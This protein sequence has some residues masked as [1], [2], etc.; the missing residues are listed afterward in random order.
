M[1]YK[2][3][4]LSAGLGSRMQMYPNLHKSLLPLGNRTVISRILDQFKESTIVVALGYKSSQVRSYLEFFHPDRHFEFVYVDNYDKRGSGPG[5]SLFCCRHNL[6]CP[7]VFTSSDTIVNP[8]EHDLTPSHDWVGVG[9]PNWSCGTEYCNFSEDNGFW[10]GSKQ[11]VYIGM[12][13]VLNYQSFW[14][15]LSKPNIVRNEH[16]VIDGLSSLKPKSKWFNSWIDTGNINSYEYAKSKFSQIVEEKP[17]ETIFIDNGRVAKFFSESKTVENRIKRADLLREYVPTVTRIDDNIYGYS[18]VDGDLLSNVVDESK[19]D[20]FVSFLDKFASDTFPYASFAEDCKYMYRDKIYERVEKHPDKI[21]LESVKKI[22]GVIV[23]PIDEILNGI[24]WETIINKG[25]SV[26]IHGDLQPENIII[27]KDRVVLLDWRDSF[28]NSLVGGDL[29]YDLGKM[30]HAI[31][32]NG[33]MVR[34]KHFSV[35]I[36]GEEAIVD[37]KFRSNLFA[38][39]DK[40]QTF[41]LK[42]GLDWHRVE[43]LGILQLINISSMHC[44]NY[45]RFLYLFGKLEIEKYYKYFYWGDMWKPV[46]SF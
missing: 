5:Y 28:G 10:F 9:L 24:D 7:F 14:E 26:K 39:K 30:Y 35:S 42:K 40:M 27:T 33:E 22:N 11:N 32:V 23:R 15:N 1:P 36:S 12:I 19:M 34:K 3:C 45:S 21:F 4:I 6:N 16:Q 29:Y 20:L 13:G 25:I 37:I 44:G 43:L 41:C 18:Y 17:K 8:S 31:V 2:V 46:K 38:L